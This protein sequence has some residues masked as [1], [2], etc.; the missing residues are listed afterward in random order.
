M[1][2]TAAAIGGALGFTGTTAVVVGGAVILAT[3]VAL[4]A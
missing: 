3:T 2:F 4:T 1:G